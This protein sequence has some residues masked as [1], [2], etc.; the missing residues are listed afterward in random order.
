MIRNR[1]IVRV[2]FAV[3]VFFIVVALFRPFD[4]PLHM[5][6]PPSRAD[7][8]VSF[9]PSSF[10]WTTVRQRYPA[11]LTHFLPTGSPKRFP[12]VQHHFHDYIHDRSWNSYKTH[13]WLRDELAPVSGGGKTTF[14]GWAA[15]LVDALD[16]LWIM[17]FRDEFLS[18]AAAA[19][20]MD[21][22][23]TTETS[24][25][26]FETTIRHLGG[27]LSAYD[28]SGQTA[29][30]EKATELGN[31]LYMAFDTPNRLP[32]FWLNFD[33]A[34]KGAQIAGTND[35]SACPTSL[36]LEF[37]RLSQL[38]GDPKFYDAA[39]RVTDFL[40]RTQTSSRLPGMW[41]KLIN[42]RDETVD[43]EIGFT[44]G[45]LADSLYE[46]LPKMAILLGRRE[47]RYEK[48]YRAAMEVVVEQLVFR[49]MVPPEDNPHDILFVG[50]AY[51]HADRIDHV[52]EG[53]HLSCF[54]GGMFG[55]GG[56]LFNIP[57][58]IDIGERIARGCGWAYD[59]FPT[60]LM[61]EIFGLVRCGSVKEPC[62]WDEAKWKKEGGKGLK[63]GFS[64]AR[65]PK[66]ILRPEAIES[67]F[68]LYRMTG[69]EGLRDVAWRMFESII[70]STKTELAHSAI[71]DVTVEGETEK[72][73]SME[74]FFLAETLKY[75]YLMFSPPDVISLDEFVFNT[76]AH[77]FRRPK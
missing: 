41:P 13:A 21:W 6:P 16:T 62:V 69:K 40:E 53:Q 11:K 64:N 76:E 23:N 28:L 15:T 73:D 72:K 27:L 12:P 66:Y 25:N 61:P 2:F 7:P 65:D 17:D 19:A 9:Q 18:A 45:A 33:D 38:T 56:K 36:S 63:K 14:G 22:A 24:A 8:P 71:A 59:A 26:L 42:F 47:P 49:P 70:K 29:L 50:D 37:T 57:E 43:Q 32:G 46:Y 1:R 31:M 5:R 75:F 58:H 60:G 77:P 10:D 4:S 54:V 48:M 20:Q 67:L 3:V 44:L 68:L 35:P 55:L 30:L 39:S 52:P 34:K 51:V 74:S